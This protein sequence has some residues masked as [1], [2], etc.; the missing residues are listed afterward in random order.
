MKTTVAL[1]TTLAIFLF[2]TLVILCEGLRAEDGLTFIKRQ[3]R[4]LILNGQPWY[5]IG[6]NAYFLLQATQQ[7]NTL[8]VD[9]TLDEAR[10][11]GCSVIRTW[12][13]QDD[14]GKGMALQLSP[15]VYDE[16][17]FQS[18]DLV[19]KKC[20]DRQLRLILVFVNNWKEY[21]GIGQYIR[22]SPTA[23]TH[24]DFFT[25]DA[26][27]KFYKEYL[28]TIV[29]R[30]NSL[31]GTLYRDEPTILAWELINEPISSDR[32]GRLVRQW[33]DTMGM[34][35]KSLDPN[36]LIGVGEAGYDNN[37]IA[38]K[39][40]LSD[41][42][43]NDQRLYWLIDGSKGVSFT[44]NIQSPLIDYAGVNLYPDAWKLSLVQAKQLIEDRIE[45]ARQAGKPFL[46]NE[47]GKRKNKK[48]AFQ[49][50]LS[51][52]FL[53]EGTGICLWQLS[54]RPPYNA[55]GF[56][57]DQETEREVLEYISSAVSKIPDL[58]V[59][60]EKSQEINEL[61]LIEDGKPGSNAEMH[62]TNTS[63]QDSMG[64]TVYQ[65]GK[66]GSI[67]FYPLG[68]L[69]GKQGGTLNITATFYDSDS[70]WV[71]SYSRGQWLSG[72]AKGK[73]GEVNVSIPLS[74]L[75]LEQ[76]SLEWLKFYSPSSVRIGIQQI[77]ISQSGK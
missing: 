70:V 22:W 28:K 51:N 10:R 8:L 74:D 47:L 13:F 6:T 66:D 39:H 1:K 9:S 50:L 2:P 33:V 43:F 38:Y 25:D 23:K 56:G 59:P 5:F 48:T 31:T 73:K 62:W 34:Y 63:V 37:I 68:L 44:M 32:S 69:F 67:E 45:I 72:Y 16:S 24:D 11:Y 30:R 64:Y 7:G 49:F 21:G 41:I 60:D 14:G 40:F 29:L 36:H 3:G 53:S 17:F 4:H 75:G 27:R 54:A 15:G 61:V 58:P 19:V 35:L 57:F 76:S 12:G 65:F 71:E 77:T 20:K 52:F 18:L 42:Q 55:D 26:C 46:V